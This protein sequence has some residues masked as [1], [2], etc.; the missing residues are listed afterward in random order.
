MA[1]A[2]SVVGVKG[3]VDTSAPFESVKAAVY[4]FEGAAA[5]AAAATWRTQAPVQF[6]LRPEEMEL[7][8]VEEQTV[9]LEMDLFVK[10]RETLK[11]LKELEMIKRT[12]DGLKLQLQQE[13]SEV[14][15]VAEIYSDTMKVHPVSDVEEKCPIYY[16]N[17][18]ESVAQSISRKQ[19]PGKTLMELKQAKAYLN[20]TAGGLSGPGPQTTIELLKSQIE[21]EKFL[22]EKTRGRVCS[23]TTK[24]SFLEQNLSKVMAELQSIR[25]AKSKGSQSPSDLWIRIKQLNSEKEKHKKMTEVSRS[26]IVRLTAE[27]EQTKCRTKTANVRLLMAK[28]MKEAAKSSEAVALAEFKT[29]TDILKSAIIP[30]TVT[31]SIEDYTTLTRKAREAHEI[32]QTRV[33][34]AMLE[35]EAANKSE[36]ELLEKVEEVTADVATGRKALEEA[37]M[38]EDAANKEKLAVEEALRRLRSEHNQKTRF[39]H[40]STKFKN[41]S[42]TPRRGDT[43]LLDVNG[44]SL[45]N[46]SK[47]I[48]EPTLSIGQILS[49]KLMGPEDTEARMHGKIVKRSKVSLGQI[50][51]QK[52]EL[53]S[54]PRIDDS[55]AHKHFFT[56]RKKF[57]F[58]GFTL[59][60]AKNKKKKKKKKAA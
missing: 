20:K 56:T 49:R 30:S 59:L 51:S 18:V 54:P 44:L 57:G 7:M 3:E 17:R 5:A 52:H 55:I 10:E 1:Q 34:A 13:T 11:V 21:E 24:A 31:V 12:I 15:K 8:K 9:K 29:M 16:N 37:L 58:V 53:L 45:I 32:S 19:S 25:D 43:Q 60:L 22:L 14:N 41:Y 4:R 2:M 46:K 40:N 47:S 48:S 38:R 6:Y 27:I 28:K 33:E 50:L 26:E 36:L 35:V 39:S 23:N 42:A